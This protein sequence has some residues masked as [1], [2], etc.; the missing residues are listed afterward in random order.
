MNFCTPVVLDG[1][2][3]ESILDFPAL[4]KGVVIY[5]FNH[6]DFARGRELLERWM[7][8]LQERF[9]HFLVHL[10]FGNREDN[11]IY[12]GSP[13]LELAQEVIQ[14]WPFV[15]NLTIHPG[16]RMSLAQIE[17]MYPTRDLREK[18]LGE[19]II[20]ALLG[21]GEDRSKMM[22]ENL[23]P[24]CIHHLDQ[25]Y[26]L[27]L[28][29]AE[30]SRVCV[31]AGVGFCLDYCHCRTAEREWRAISQGLLDGSLVPEQIPNFHRQYLSEIVDLMA[32][33]PAAYQDLPLGLLHWSTIG[34]N[35][36]DHGSV[37]TETGEIERMKR[38]LEYT[39]IAHGLDYLVLET[40]ERDHQGRP[41]MLKLA[42][43]FEEF[44]L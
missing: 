25:W 15:A 5:L 40:E 6:D 19:V 44:A 8:R 18:H 34:T 36:Q 28:Y 4:I 12:P 9:A 39:L 16:S 14:A 10:P 31:Q 11:A 7:P 1:K 22:I 37:P 27:S 29:P 2:R 20:P 26:P 23:S 30:I 43:M 17:D 33:G 41:N 3:F 32:D 24:H 38:F 35:I 21:L 42:T 13:L